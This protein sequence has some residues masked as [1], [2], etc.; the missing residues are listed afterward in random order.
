MRMTLLFA[1]L[2]A[3]AGSAVAQ[4][5]IYHKGVVNAASLMAPDLPGGAVAQGSI[6]SIYGTNLGPAAGATVSAFPLQTTFQNVSI[7]VF[8]GK[9]SVSALPIY[10][11]ATQINAIMPSNAPLGRVSVQV[12]YNAGTSGCF[13][14]GNAPCYGPTSNPAP[15]TVVANRFGIFAVKGGG[16]GPGIL[17]NFV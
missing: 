12:T 7:Q 14:P 2:M 8:Q 13:G 1:G 9:T 6:F 15:V 4:P 16:F 17:Q 5:Y 3:A 10:V 11:S